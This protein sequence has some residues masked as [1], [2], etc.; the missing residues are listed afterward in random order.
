MRTA[1]LSINCRINGNLPSRP[2]SQDHPFV[3]LWKGQGVRAGKDEQPSETVLLA[4]LTEIEM[5]CRKGT[6]YRPW[7]LETVVARDR[8]LIALRCE[9]TCRHLQ[10]LH[11]R[12]WLDD[13]GWPLAELNALINARKAS[14][15]WP[16]MCLATA[17][18][19]VN[20]RTQES[21]SLI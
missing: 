21:A 2:R 13:R 7:P 3:R 11:E 16:N 18:A 19:F 1:A 17:K 12:S 20:E 15:P 8:Q 14:L 4:R 5:S 6:G 9:R 10:S